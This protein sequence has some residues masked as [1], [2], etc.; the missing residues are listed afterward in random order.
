MGKTWKTGLLMAILLGIGLMGLASPAQAQFRIR[1]EDLDLGVGAIITDQAPGDNIAVVG[2]VNYS[3]TI[4]NFLVTVNTGLSK[5]LLSNGYAEMDLNFTVQTMTG[6][7]IRITLEDNGFTGGSPGNLILRASIGGTLS[8]PAGSSLTAQSTVNTS[9]NY[10][11]L[12]ADTGPSAAGVAL[13]AI[14]GTPAGT[15]VNAFSPIFT[16]PPFDSGI[17]FSGSGSAG[18]TASGPY[19]LYQQVVINLTGNGSVT[20][21]LA[22]QVLPGPGGLALALTAVPG[23]GLA[24]LRRRFKKT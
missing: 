5:P 9:N 2:G 19:A 10:I 18:F 16:A 17:A 21:D 6:G 20:G 15:N 22:T 4:G 23:F 14:G 24:W 11:A 1:V 13:P 8:G 7:R 3:G 12:G